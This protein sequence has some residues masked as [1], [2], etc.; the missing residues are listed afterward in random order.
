MRRIE[1]RCVHQAVKKSSLEKKSDFF[2]MTEKYKK[3]RKMLTNEDVKIFVPKFPL[4]DCNICLLT[5]VEHEKNNRKRPLTTMPNYEDMILPKQT[6]ANGNDCYCYI[7]LTGRFND[8]L[9]IEKGKC[10]VSNHVDAFNGFHGTSSIIQSPSTEKLND[11][12]IISI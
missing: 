10:G 12:S 5:F 1:Q 8:H 11:E 2:R 6:R 7:C 3:L 9:K 4:S